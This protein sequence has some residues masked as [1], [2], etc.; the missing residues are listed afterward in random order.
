MA[1]M[2]APS[3]HTLVQCSS[4][5]EF[6]RD[7]VDTAMESNRLSADH[8][9]SHYVVNLL[10]LFASADAWHEATTGA[11][12]RKALA[13]M[14]ADALDAPTQE[15]RCTNLQNLGDVALF[16]AGFFAGDFE[17][18]VV[19]LDYYVSIGGTAY[20]SLSAETRGTARGRA[21]GLVFAELSE[22][23]QQFVDVLNDIRAPGSSS[24]ADLVR[25]YELWRTTGSARAARLLREQGVHL[26]PRSV[27]EQQH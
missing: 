13:L 4:L 25:Q 19:D 15:Q 12:R 21:F 11:P 9:T 1:R 5:R 17:D 22:K 26:F 6:F 14:L 10:T 27:R 16:V 3:A 7:S 20:A 18:S 24:D 8:H 23:F 2:S